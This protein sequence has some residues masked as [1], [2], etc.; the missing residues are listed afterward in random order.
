MK[1]HLVILG[2]GISGLSLAW[3]L[4]KT[5]GNQFKITLLEKSPHLGGWFSS[6]E[7]EGFTFDTGPHYIFTTEGEE[8][9]HLI[10][11]LNLNQEMILSKRESNV[12]RICK[13]DKI[14]VIPKTFKKMLF[15]PLAKGLIYGVI[16]DWLTPPR[17]QDD[18]DESVYDFIKRRFSRTLANGFSEAYLA[19][20]IS[21]D[22]KKLSMK[23]YLSR[24]LLLEKKYGS[25]VKGLM[26]AKSAPQPQNEKFIEIRKHA[27]LNFKK[28]ISTLT[29]ALGSA[30]AEHIVKK[31]VTTLK[32]D[33]ERIKVELEDGETLYAD[34]LF[35]TLPCFS[36]AN[37][38]AEEH[39]AIK[40]TLNGFCYKS[41]A[42]VSI[43]YR[44]KHL[45]QE[46]YGYIIP[47][48]EQKPIIGVL[49]DSSVFPQMSQSEEE[50]RFTVMIGEDHL[51]TPFEQMTEEDFK[52]LALK[53]I[54]QHMHIKASPD[55]IHVTL[56]K[57]AVPKFFVGHDEKVLEVV[58]K[59]QDIA[60]QLT[61][62]G[63]G[64]YGAAISRCILN[65][66][67]AATE[68]RGC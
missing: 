10:D 14:Y 19:G 66:K 62:L 46:G 68:F 58:G 60:P 27:A 37:I 31:E 26:Q 54:E 63:S 29:D 55:V 51:P 32:F 4:Q 18:E 52:T 35:S 34:H 64:F 36:L 3:Y 43:G 42:I 23:S 65:A 13:N 22:I 7:K 39:H 57:K 9:F 30:L 21:G 67:K 15:S 8:I 59:L 53:E 61:V 28:G 56:V 41:M 49:W 11:A 1:K 50:T 17:A 44:A 6:I 48:S 5:H 20:I 38:L 45:D 24:I 40:N 12:S 16:H 33:K 2:G 47:Y 25:V